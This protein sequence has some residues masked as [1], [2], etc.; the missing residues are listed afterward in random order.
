MD[1]KTANY[2][3]RALIESGLKE[4]KRHWLKSFHTKAKIHVSEFLLEHWNLLYST[5]EEKLAD[6]KD[7]LEKNLAHMNDMPWSPWAQGQ[8]EALKEYLANWKE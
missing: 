3:N 4:L 1:A 6:N 7:M 8:G 5:D 2:E